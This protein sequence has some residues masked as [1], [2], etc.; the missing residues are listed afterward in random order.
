MRPEPCYECYQPPVKS[1]DGLSASDIAAGLG[2][3]VDLED[4]SLEDC[5]LVLD[6]GNARWVGEEVRGRGKD[7]SRPFR[8][9]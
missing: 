9:P 1:A 8:S 5:S 4:V 3:K 2:A 7:I 6:L